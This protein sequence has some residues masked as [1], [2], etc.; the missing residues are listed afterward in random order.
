VKNQFSNYKVLHQNVKKK[1]NKKKVDYQ[2]KTYLNINTPLPVLYQRVY[3]LYDIHVLS[4]HPAHG[5][6]RPPHFLP[7]FLLPAQA[8]G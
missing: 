8:P 3:I 6:F 2:I 4:L 5:Y 1:N 7:F